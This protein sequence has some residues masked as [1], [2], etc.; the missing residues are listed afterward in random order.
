MLSRIEAD[1]KERLRASEQRIEELRK[2]HDEVFAFERKG[3]EAALEESRK[4]TEQLAAALVDKDELVQRYNLWNNYILAALDKY[5]HGFISA[6][7]AHVVDPVDPQ[8]QQV[9]ELYAPRAVLEDPEAKV[10]MERIAYRLLQLKVTNQFDTRTEESAQTTA[11]PSESH[12]EQ[13]INRQERLKKAITETETS[14]SQLDATCGSVLTRLY[15]FSDNLEQSIAN[16]PRNVLAPVKNVVFVCLSIYNGQLLWADDADTMRTAVI[17]MHSTIRLK[18]SEYG[19]YEAF[20]DDVSMLLAF[21]D[22]AGAC[23]FCT[24]SQMWLM[25]VPWPAALLSSPFC[26]EERGDDQRPI[27]R[28]IRLAMAM[29]AGES[30]VESSPIPSATGAYRSHYYGRAVSQAVHVA[31]LAQGGQILISKQAWLLCMKKSHELGQLIVT[32]MGTFPLLS[33]NSATGVQEKQTVEILQ[34]STPT[35]KSR[36]FQSL[37]KVE[38][39]T[40]SSLT[41]MK[42]CTLVTEIDALESRRAALFEVVSMLKEEYNTLSSELAGLASRTRQS[43]MHFHLLPP[44]EMVVQMNDLYSIIERVAVRSEEL[45]GDLQHV[46]SVIEDLDMQAKGF[47]STTNNRS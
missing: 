37:A 2:T 29:H 39:P 42:K 1:Y 26:V 16:A 27:F 19:G 31:T 38:V 24:E 6:L 30:F 40:V 22:A 12:L 21:D 47:A 18:L 43:K 20:S 17:L 15:F 46:E 32:E 34:I 13:L 44:P 7:P 10:V 35:L 36:R 8:L 45:F 28:G 5:Y 23:R 41:G 3:K 9:P 25:H 14:I 33:F 11:L 4:A